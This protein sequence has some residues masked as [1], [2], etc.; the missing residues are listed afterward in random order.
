[1]VDFYNRDPFFR[2]GQVAGA[3]APPNQFGAP[4]IPGMPPQ[5]APVGPP[6]AAPMAPPAAPP[7]AAPSGFDRMMN[8]P[9][10]AM[11]FQGLNN[12]A[13]MRTG[14][15]PRTDPFT[16]YQS[17]VATQAEQ[18]IRER[19][20]ERA[21]AK[22]DREQRPTADFDAFVASRPELQGKP[23]ADQLAAWQ[24]FNRAN[25]SGVS[26][27]ISRS[28]VGENGN[29]FIVRAD[30]TVEDT[31]V[32]GSPPGQRLVERGGVTYVE[33]ELPGG[34]IR[35]M[36]LDEWEQKRREGVIESEAGAGERGKQEAQ[37]DAG[38]IEKA[39]EEVYAYEQAA[40]VADRMLRV[41][42]EYEQMLE[43]GTLSTGLIDN[44]LLDFLGVG[45]QELAAMDA[46]AVQQTLEN[47]QITNLA[48]V[49]ENEMRTIA[50]LWANAFRQEEPNLGVLRRA[51]RETK[52]LQDK[53]QRRAKAQGDRLKEY[54]GESEY[55]RLRRANPW[56]NSLYL[57]DEGAEVDLEG[58]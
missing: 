48:P 22:W 43:D 20:D 29:M 53:I 49:T 25:T 30:G 14:Q 34:E 8:S 50:K 16:A 3:I 35:T 41:S 1:M 11:A 37:Y 10:A 54:G 56:F 33:E 9:Y 42:E 57:E 28:F 2:P 58:V 13:G 18:R 51:I 55:G 7:G 39:T 38:Q 46:E 21:Q 17:A 6:M 23:Y 27:R 19:M 45:T 52:L 24:E 15:M 4:T 26:N 44:F 32:K 40:G 31:G 36:P 5:A 12:L 47:L